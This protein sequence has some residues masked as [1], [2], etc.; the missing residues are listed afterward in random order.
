[1]AQV[2]K[3]AKAKPALQENPQKTSA[4]SAETTNPAEEPKKSHLWIWALVGVAVAIV[5]ILLFAL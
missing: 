2:Q 3:T 1:M 4:P 5:L